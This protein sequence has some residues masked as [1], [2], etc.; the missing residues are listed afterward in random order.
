MQAGQGC[1]QPG[2]WAG[3][4][5][6]GTPPLSASASPE[7]A[8]GGQSTRTRTTCQGIGPRLRLENG[9]RAKGRKVSRERTACAPRSAASTA[10]GVQGR[11]GRPLWSEGAGPAGLPPP[12]SL[13]VPRAGSPALH[14]ALPADRRRDRGACTH[15][16]N[17]MLSASPPRLT[18]GWERGRFLGAHLPGEA[19]SK[20]SRPAGAKAGQIQ[21]WRTDP[22][23]H[24][25]PA[26]CPG[27]TAVS[28]GLSIPICEEPHPQL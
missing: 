5:C 24:L 9:A 8:P 23:P 4:L 1:P 3:T 26:H 21:A 13:P 18:P 22:W 17:L 20:P 11:A 7:G 2:P 19:G 15:S 6:A 25:T 27:H 10:G 16:Y 28:L 14:T 12:P